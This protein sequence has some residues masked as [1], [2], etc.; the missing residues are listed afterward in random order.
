MGS[1]GAL[2]FGKPKRVRRKLSYHGESDSHHFVM[3]RKNN[4]FSNLTILWVSRLPLCRAESCEK[5][6]EVV[7]AGVAQDPDCLLTL[8]CFFHLTHLLVYSSLLGFTTNALIFFLLPVI[9]TRY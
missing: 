8:T 1:L 9:L 5:G 4:E 7:L 6:Q 3:K 2:E